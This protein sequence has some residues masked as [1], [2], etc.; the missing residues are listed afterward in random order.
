MVGCRSTLANNR[1]AAAA[2]VLPQARRTVVP[3]RRSAV[4]SKATGATEVMQLANHMTDEIFTAAW[5]VFAMTLL[6]VAVG[7]VLLRVE[8]AVEDE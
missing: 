6:G 2:P 5:V 3:A 8:A 1:M 4:V 7:F